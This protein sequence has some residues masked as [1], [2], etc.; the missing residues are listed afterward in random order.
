MAAPWEN[1]VDTDII[2]LDS[3][4]FDI[5]TNLAAVSAILLFLRLA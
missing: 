4:R 2:R 1:T 3:S 5:A